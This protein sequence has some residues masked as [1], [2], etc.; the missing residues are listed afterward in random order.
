LQPFTQKYALVTLL[1]PAL[2]AGRIPPGKARALLYGAMAFILIPPAI[3]GAAAQ[4]TMQAMGLDFVATALICAAT[5]VFLCS[6]RSEAEE[7]KPAL[8]SSGQS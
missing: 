5:V 6:D 7:A 3:P 1:W 8:K 2:V 4:R